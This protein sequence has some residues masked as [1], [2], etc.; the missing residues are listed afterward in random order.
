[1]LVFW[2]K[3]ELFNIIGYHSYQE[4]FLTGHAINQHLEAGLQKDHE[5]EASLGYI[6]RPTNKQRRIIPPRGKE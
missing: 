2:E 5:F 6:S 3:D 1:L 4:L